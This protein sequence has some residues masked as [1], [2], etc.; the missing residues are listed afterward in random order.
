MRVIKSLNAHG[1]SSSMGACL[2]QC[3]LS[4]PHKLVLMCR[5]AGRS[6]LPLSD[7]RRLKWDC[8]DTPRS[9]VHR[10]QRSTRP[11]TAWC[12]RILCDLCPQA[13]A[14]ALRLS[15]AARLYERVQEAVSGQ[16]NACPSEL[17]SVLTDARGHTHHLASDLKSSKET[18]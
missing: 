3:R 14:L 4:L 17:A 6:R 15:L 11:L 5:I 12:G 18:R 13:A 2:F 16:S 7:P 9:A 10:A 1:A 8:A